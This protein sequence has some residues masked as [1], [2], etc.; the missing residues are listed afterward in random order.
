MRKKGLFVVLFTFMIV[1][2]GACGADEDYSK[3]LAGKEVIPASHPNIAYIGRVSFADPES[4][5]FN[6]PGVEIRAVFEGTSLGMMVKKNSGYFMVTIDNG[7]PFKV[8][9]GKNNSIVTLADDLS[10]GMHEVKVMLV[11]EAFQ[12]NPEFRGFILDEGKTLPVA[13][14]LPERKMEFIG[15]SITCG[16]GNEDT[17]PDANFKDETE[18]HY[19]TYAAAT[20]R[21]FDAQSMVVARS[22]IGI[23]RNFGGPVTGSN[24]CLPAIYNKTLF[25]DSRETWDFSRYT[26][27]VDCI[28]LGTNDVGQSYDAGLLEEGYRSFLKTLRG[29]YPKAKIIFLTGSMLGGDRLRV[30]QT[31]LDKVTDEANAAGDKEVY[32]FDMS[33]QD[34]KL[35]YG[36]AWHPSKEQQLKGASE[37]I[38]FIQQIT[39]WDVVQTF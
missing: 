7:E 10:E 13:P 2:S 15:N 18:N 39:G 30:V 12:R 8:E 17:D 23:Y 35:G 5:C 29:N 19:Y 11:Y 34:G 21:A 38:P 31:A 24:D 4:P 6:Y 1:L 37:L 27:D 32:R 25:N 28:N 14:V 3:L 33:P 36:A 22:G 16:F 26:P 20:A 9:S